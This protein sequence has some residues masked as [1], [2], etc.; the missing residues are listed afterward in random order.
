MSR[1]VLQTR[2]VAVR[3]LH[4]REQRVL[5]RSAP[6][7]MR[8]LESAP[9]ADTVA[10]RVE[11]H[12]RVGEIARRDGHRQDVHRDPLGVEQDGEALGDVEIH[13]D[14]GQVSPRGASLRNEAAEL[15]RSLIG[16]PVT[17]LYPDAARTGRD[18]PGYGYSDRSGGRW[19]RRR[20]RR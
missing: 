10:I 19:A 20:T 16:L 11:R 13:I 7:A 1:V 8:H 2:R 18:R 5:E 9:L 6:R 12:D 4:V 3:L 17:D 14:L 15:I